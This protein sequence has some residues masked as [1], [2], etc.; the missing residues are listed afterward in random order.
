MLAG[1]MRLLLVGSLAACGVAGNA[2]PKL[3]G[4]TDR[5]VPV[6][7]DAPVG[8]DT[9]PD[10]LGAYRHSIQIDGADDFVAAEQ[11]PTTSNAYAARIAW[12]DHAVYVGY[13]G[14]D[15][16]PAALDTANKWLF[17][18]IDVDPGAATGGATSLRYNTQQA[19]FPSGFGAELYARW[20]C[21][22]TFASIEH[23]AAD[24]TYTTIDTP[25][26]AQSGTFVEL[27]IPRTLLG[28]ATSIGVVTWMIN[29]KPT[30]EGNFAGLY[31]DNFADGYSATL[32]LTRYLRV[33]FASP[34]QP[35]DPSH[36]AP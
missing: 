21:D 13:S 2:G 23:R 1:V 14:P 31:P 35:N 10:E 28:G 30:F 11:F 16:D 22:G 5:D 8:F 33:D 12:D 25:T 27:A 4:G 3:D 36:T 15:L 19:T 34:A 18:Y 20:R 26:S 32:P 29:E 24:D 6:G 9:P 7:F 17:V